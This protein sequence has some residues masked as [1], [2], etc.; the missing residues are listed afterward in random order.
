MPRVGG[1]MFSDLA[2]KMYWWLHRLSQLRCHEDQSRYCNPATAYAVDSKAYF[3][4]K[5]SC[6]SSWQVRLKKKKAIED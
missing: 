5:L 6:C 2:Q 1:E 3:V 4:S